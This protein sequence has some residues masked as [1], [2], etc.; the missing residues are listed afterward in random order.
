MTEGTGL[1]AANWAQT[2]RQPTG[3]FFIIKVI[4]PSMYTSTS[5]ASDFLANP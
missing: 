1:M 4:S 5:I 3:M 2:T